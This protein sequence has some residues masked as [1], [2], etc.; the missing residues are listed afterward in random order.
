M[1]PENFVRSTNK[2]H[3][4]H[5][6]EFLNFTCGRSSQVQ[7]SPETLQNRAPKISFVAGPLETIYC[8]AVTEYHSSYSEKSNKRTPQNHIQKRRLSETNHSERVEPVI[9]VGR[10]APY[11]CWM[12]IISLKMASFT[13]VTCKQHP[14]K[15]R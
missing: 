15:A 4:S 6:L 5:N 10:S 8:C 7:Q 9:G 12:V 1:E 14:L 2:D 3:K 13:R 11:C